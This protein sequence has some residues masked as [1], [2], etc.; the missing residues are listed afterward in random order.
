[1]T[2]SVKPNYV[3]ML[4]VL[5]RV[6]YAL[7][8]VPTAADHVIKFAARL[9]E[10]VRLCEDRYFEEITGKCAA[11]SL[12][13]YISGKSAKDLRNKMISDLESSSFF[14]MGHSDVP[15]VSDEQ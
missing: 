7:A 9:K 10:L 12:S 4:V 15:I 13:T 14:F 8:G 6:L 5:A 2:K 3:H 11:C 1:M